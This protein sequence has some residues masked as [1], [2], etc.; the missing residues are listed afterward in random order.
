MLPS[1]EVLAAGVGFSPPLNAECP[2]SA[3]KR[4][5]I[6]ARPSRA[7]RDRVRSSHFPCGAAGQ[8]PPPMPASVVFCRRSRNVRKRLPPAGTSHARQTSPR[9]AP[10]P[11]PEN[12]LRRT[13]A[14][15]PQLPL[16]L[17]EYGRMCRHGAT[18]AVDAPPPRVAR[19]YAARPPPP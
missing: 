17:P 4:A 9:H 15:A 18:H 11:A 19:Q 6:N 1:A 5:T 13:V 2:G 8:T 16:P 14:A 12:A 10:P 7:A 3:A